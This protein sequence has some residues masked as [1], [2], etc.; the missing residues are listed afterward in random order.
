MAKVEIEKDRCKSCELCMSFCKKGC[1]SVGKQMNTSGYFV[2][3]YTNQ[4]ECNGCG[5]CGEMCPDLALQ[6]WK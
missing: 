4:E 5:L 6:V 3:E 2:I 1:L